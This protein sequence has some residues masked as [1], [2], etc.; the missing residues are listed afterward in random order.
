MQLLNV[1]KFLQ[2]IHS[3]RVDVSGEE[4]SRVDSPK[5]LLLSPDLFLECEDIVLQVTDDPFEV[6]LKANYEVCTPQVT[7]D[8]TVFVCTYTHCTLTSVE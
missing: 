1:K 5:R 2:K 8:L 6:K 4:E 3:S 7:S